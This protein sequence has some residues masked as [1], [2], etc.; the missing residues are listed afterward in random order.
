MIRLIPVIEITY[1]Q[2]GERSPE[3]GLPREESIRHWDLFRQECFEKA[4][5]H[6]KMYPYEIGS[7]LYRLTDITNANLCKYI[8]DE[9]EDSEKNSEYLG[10]L[11]G[12]YI[13]NI[14]GGDKLYPQC[15]GDLADLAEWE[16]LLSDKGNPTFWIGHPSP[17]VI[18][19]GDVIIFDLEHPNLPEPFA[20][21]N[22]ELYIDVSK[23]DLSKA[24]Q[25]TKKELDVFTSR[26]LKINEKEQ[27]NIENIAQILIYGKY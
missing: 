22:D 3:Y 12:G 13:L 11:S 4:G 8:L 25:E 14:D 19:K 6:D 1:Y 21:Q 23:E 15:C 27:L 26:L 17:S 9:W 20:Y 5:F 24:I 10:S 16:N 2:F 7:S 18:D